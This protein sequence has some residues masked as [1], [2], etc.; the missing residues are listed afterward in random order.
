MTVQLGIDY[1]QVIQLV[2]Q[3]SQAEQDDLIS[4]LLLRR[5]EQRPLTVE[6]KLRLFDLAKIHAEVKQTPS[7]RREDW[8]DDDGR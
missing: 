3:L 4:K 1:E 7:P 6:E 8:Y 5:A 2:E